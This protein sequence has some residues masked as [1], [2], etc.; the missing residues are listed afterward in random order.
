MVPEGHAFHSNIFS[1]DYPTFLKC[2]AGLLFDVVKQKL[3]CSDVKCKI[4]WHCTCVTPYFTEAED[5]VT[6]KTQRGRGGG[7]FP[8][9]RVPKVIPPS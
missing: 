5:C 1:S 3:L 9:R 7:N 4:Y 6:V 8:R 2:L